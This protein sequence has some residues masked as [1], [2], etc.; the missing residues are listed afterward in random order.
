MRELAS[1][2]IGLGLNTSKMAKSIGISKSLYEKVEYGQ[3]KPS[4]NF[5]SKFKE[6]YPHVD[7]NIF[8]KT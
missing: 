7:I 1:I 3:R 2:R 6:K 5:I 4:R 8:F